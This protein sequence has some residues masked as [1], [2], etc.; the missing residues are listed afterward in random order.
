M[1]ET[2]SRKW[3]LFGK[4]VLISGALAIVAYA[5]ATP[6]NRGVLLRPQ[7]GTLLKPIGVGCTV[8]MLNLRITTG[9][10]DLRGGKDN[11]TVEIHFANG[12]M[13]TAANVNKGANWPNQSVN[14]ASINLTR[15]VAPNEIKQS[16]PVHTAQAGYHSPS[17]RHSA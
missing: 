3:M 8:G 13:Q 10:D 2:K 17:P 12:D 1:K 5:Q 14:T 6:P 15:K 4:H 16:C 11:L 9:N 7:S